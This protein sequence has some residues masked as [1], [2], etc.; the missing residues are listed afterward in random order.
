ML[1]IY[2]MLNDTDHTNLVISIVAQRGMERRPGD[3]KLESEGE[4]GESTQKTRI[5]LWAVLDF[6]W[7]A[8]QFSPFGKGCVS[9]EKPREDETCQE[10]R[11]KFQWYV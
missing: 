7:A 4:K 6:V 11:A 5:N 2:E 9:A 8:E 3:V 1:G 10:Q